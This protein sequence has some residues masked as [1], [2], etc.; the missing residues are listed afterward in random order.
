MSRVLKSMKK[1]RGNSIYHFATEPVRVRW[2][3]RSHMESS[4]K[5]LDENQR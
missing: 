3:S 5:E 1:P 4:T 2:K